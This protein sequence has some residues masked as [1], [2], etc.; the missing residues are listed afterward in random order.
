MRVSVYTVEIDGRFNIWISLNLAV[1]LWWW[2]VAGECK[3]SGRAADKLVILSYSL[4]LG[5]AVKLQER[6]RFNRMMC[7]WSS[8]EWA[9][10]LN[11]SLKAEMRR[12]EESGGKQQ[13]TWMNHVEVIT[14][15]LKDPEQH[16]CWANGDTGQDI[17]KSQPCVSSRYG[18]VLKDHRES[19]GIAVDRLVETLSGRSLLQ[20]EVE[21][22][23]AERLPGMEQDWQSVAQLAYLQGRLKLQAAV[24]AG[25]EGEWEEWKNHRHEKAEGERADCRNNSSRKVERNRAGRSNSSS[26]NAEGKR[27]DRSNSLNKRAED[28]G[29]YVRSLGLAAALRLPLLLWRRGASRRRAVERCLRC[30]SVATGRTPCAAPTA[31]PASRSGAAGPA[32]CCCAARRPR[33]CGARPESAPP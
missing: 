2:S 7:R 15:R 23:L 30:G 16:N 12:E 24:S 32:R 19:L 25:M 28:S 29:A 27:G 6:F 4:P 14:E 13:R 1:D 9:A 21:A 10:Y 18:N 20:P 8:E 17:G 22:L 11:D 33:P 31:R 26:G 5:W 3:W